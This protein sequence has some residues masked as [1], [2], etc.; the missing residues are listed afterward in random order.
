MT[1]SPSQPDHISGKQGTWAV[2]HQHFA[3]FLSHQKVKSVAVLASQIRD[4][5]LPPEQRDHAVHALASITGRKFH[6]PDSTSGLADI[7]LV[8]SSAP[9]FLAG[10][11]PLVGAVPPQ[12][13]PQANNA[14]KMDDAIA[15]A[16]AWLKLQNH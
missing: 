1:I 3:K 4:P 2:L 15:S 13:Q 16:D 10:S 6:R 12:I 7:S 8:P 5:S 9:N 11:E 14:A